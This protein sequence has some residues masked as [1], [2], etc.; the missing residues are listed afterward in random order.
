MEKNEDDGKAAVKAREF[1]QIAEEVFKPIYPVISGRLLELAGIRKGVCIDVGCGGG[2]LGLAALEKGFEGS[3]ILLD[4]NPHAIEL[5]EKR[6]AGRPQVKTLCADVH[7]MPLDSASADLILSRGAMWFWD[8]EKSLAEI[9]RVLAP[10]GAAVLGGG[11]GSLELKT[12]IYRE[13]SER[14]GLDWG[15][16]R[17]K[18]TEGFSPDDYA[19]VLDAMGIQSYTVI[20]EASGDWLVLRRLS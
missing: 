4:S 9:W 15:E 17:R 13:M 18:K 11:Y 7:A 3:L 10:D 6:I 8:K 5:A 20:H 12:Q 1:D 14:N 2:H 16:Q 19:L